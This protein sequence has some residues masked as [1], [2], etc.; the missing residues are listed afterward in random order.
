MAKVIFLHPD[1]GIGGA[2]RLV[3]DAA[4]A[5]KQRGHQVQIITAHHD[6]SHCF[7]ETRN[8][9]LQIIA[10]G[11]WLPRSILGR[12]QAL[13][14]SIRMIYITFYMMCFYS[15]DVVFVDQVS[16]PLLVLYMFDFPTLFY[17]HFPDLLL[18]SG[19]GGIKA[20][21]RYPIDRLE[22]FTTGLADV[23]FVNSGFTKKVFYSTFR[24]LKKMNPVILYPSLSTSIFKQSG[25]KPSGL[26]A[27]PKSFFLSINRYERKKNLDL[28][29]QSYSRLSEE[30]KNEVS[31]VMVGGYDPRVEENVGHYEE[32]TNL[33]KSLNLEDEVEFLRSPTDEEKV[34]LLKNA[35]CLIYT[36]T[37]E[38]FG[39]VPLESMYCGTPVV[40]VNS[41]GP[42][43]TVVDGVTGWLRDPN[44][45]AF[46]EVMENV[47]KSK[48]LLPNVGKNGTLR[49]EQNFSFNAFGEK[50]ER[51]IIDLLE[52]GR[53]VRRS[54]LV[55]VAVAFHFA[56]AVSVLLWMTFGVSVP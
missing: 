26:K 30:R 11:D 42:T 40:A 51:S 29:I 32:L 25:S 9:E 54:F 16:T 55:R 14:A 17:C 52:S 34:W 35:L 50:L 53:K 33:V 10:A 27:K 37:N 15:C 19:R 1:L 7:I 49:V 45:E 39:I 22:E 38:H 18:S 47:V 2:E 6:P 36:P 41:G 4:L 24:S 21:Y 56:L 48:E 5:L 13:F 20:L 44:D 3:V 28:A 8:G 31:L 12:C 43:E 46:S 23:L